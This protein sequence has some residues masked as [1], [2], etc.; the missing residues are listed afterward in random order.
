MHMSLI[1]ACNGY[2]T[3]SD[4]WRMAPTSERNQNLHNDAEY[5]MNGWYR[6][7]F[8]GSSANMLSSP[9]SRYSCG[10]R[11]PIWWNGKQNENIS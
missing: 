5:L 9:P 6:F 11:E 1:D 10:T 3:L 8:N 7:M 2:T 4:T